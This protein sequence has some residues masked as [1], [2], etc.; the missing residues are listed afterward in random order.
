MKH[1]P[2]PSTPIQ[3]NVPVLT[4]LELRVQAQPTPLPASLIN[5]NVNQLSARQSGSPNPSTSFNGRAVQVIDEPTS[6]GD[7]DRSM[8]AFPTPVIRSP[9]RR[10]T[11][12]EDDQDRSSPQGDNE[13]RSKRTK[14][15]RNTYDDVVTVLV[16][17]YVQE[18]INADNRTESKWEKVSNKLKMHGIERSKWSIKNW[19][20][21]CGRHETG[22]E[23]RQNPTGRK[24]VTS[25]QS[26]ED[27]KKARERKKLEATERIIGKA[28]RAYVAE[29]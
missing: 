13:S 23:E 10:M 8:P 7:S 27:R 11:T 5:E 21:R 3:I 15:S 22:I 17:R 9:K 26:P 18:E 25:K 29:V 20:S 2:R 16:A 19:W 24:V 1:I 4:Q 12:L 14:N 28:A 6:I